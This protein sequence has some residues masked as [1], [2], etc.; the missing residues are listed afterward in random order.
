MDNHYL[1]LLLNN[2][3]Y[4]LDLES[5]MGIKAPIFISSQNQ[6]EDDNILGYLFMGDDEINIWDLKKLMK[7]GYSHITPKSGIILYSHDN[8]DEQKISA[9]MVE[10]IKGITPLC[11]EQINQAQLISVQTLIKE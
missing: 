3:P 4:F 2:Q 5:I 9:L 8:E 7:M 11:S 6:P 1:E 10:D